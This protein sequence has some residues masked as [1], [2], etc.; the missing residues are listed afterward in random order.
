MASKLDQEIIALAAV[1]ELIGEM[2]H[3]GHFSIEAGKIQ[4]LELRFDTS[5]S[6]KLF[7]I[8]LTDFLSLP[9]DGTL[10]LKTPKFEGCR[11]QTYLGHIQNVVADPQ[12]AGDL[13]QLKS[14]LEDFADWLD[15]FAV[16]ENVWLPSI[17]R[18]GRL[19][20]RRMDYLKI[21]GTISKHG[22]AR[23]GDVVKKI[24]TVLAANGTSIDEGQAYLILPEFQEWFQDHVFSASST[25][26]AWH[27]NEVRWGI[28][29]YLSAEFRRA[30]T[31]T[32]IVSGVQMYTYD[33]PSEIVDPLTRTIYWDLMNKMQSK[34]Y[35]PR[36]TVSRYLNNVF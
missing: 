20:V 21:C 12:F 15:G 26:I 35:F 29:Q 8:I 11:G 9:R 1:W 32:Q 17:E 27:L 22:F 16:V 13:A 28:Y 36:F 30:Y 6:S 31:P 14:S 4:D 24:V 2:V 34:P 3:F 25:R 10:G 19:K 5:E 7:L 23:L 18:E 33:T